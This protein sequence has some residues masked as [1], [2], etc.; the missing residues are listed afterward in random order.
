MTEKKALTNP[1]LNRDE[2]VSH[3]ETTL[4]LSKSYAAG[5]FEKV[6]TGER[7]DEEPS[8]EAITKV[9]MLVP[10]M[11]AS[12]EQVKAKVNNGTL[13]SAIDESRS[14]MHQEGNDS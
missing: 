12:L 2:G 8:C 14:G 4:R 10:G 9:M 7:L 3:T 1:L 5:E 6:T 11:S 13:R